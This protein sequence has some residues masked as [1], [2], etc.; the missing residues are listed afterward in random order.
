MS[1]FQQQPEVL[2]KYWMELL[3]PWEYFLIFLSLQFIV[4]FHSNRQG[5]INQSA[6]GMKMCKLNSIYFFLCCATLV[7]R[8]AL[9]DVWA[10]SLGCL[11][12]PSEFNSRRWI[13][14]ILF[15]N[16]IFAFLKK[17]KNKCNPLWSANHMESVRRWLGKY[18]PAASGENAFAD[19]STHCLINQLNSEA[20]VT[21]NP[22]FS[23]WALLYCPF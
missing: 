3:C 21:W 22:N 8:K 18:W 13:F 6:R 19:C 9:F 12:Q 23:T 17:N 10:I 11:E 20:D 2:N 4:A 15:S 16:S 7:T 5:K 14:V 1:E